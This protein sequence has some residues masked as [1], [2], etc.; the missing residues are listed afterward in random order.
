MQRRCGMVWG[1]AILAATTNKRMIA[2]ARTMAAAQQSTAAIF[3]SIPAHNAIVIM[4]TTQTLCHKQRKR[5]NTNNASVILLCPES[6][7]NGIVI[8]RFCKQVFVTF[9]NIS[10]A[11]LSH[12]CSLYSAFVL[13][14]TSG[15]ALVRLYYSTPVLLCGYEHMPIC[16]YEHRSICGYA[17]RRI[18][19][20]CV[21][22]H[23]KI[24]QG[25]RY[26][27]S[28]TL[29]TKPAGSKIS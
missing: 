23:G 19:S 26:D 21:K 29:D 25:S 8:S 11:Y 6:Q 5:D 3:R 24:D 7:N 12:K 2:P 10:S 17:H 15:L 1:R 27:P 4:Q 20:L 22:P 9:R 14:D 13:C 18:S 16:A 28:R